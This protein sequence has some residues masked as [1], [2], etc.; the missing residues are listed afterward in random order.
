MKVRRC[1][2]SCR[3]PDELASHGPILSLMGFRPPTPFDVTSAPKH[4]HALSRRRG[5]WS[6]HRGGSHRHSGAVGEP[7]VYVRT[8]RSLRL[9]TSPR[10]WTRE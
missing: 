7:R 3:L 6:Q 1:S 9:V 5:F 10:A 8:V 4:S 2:N